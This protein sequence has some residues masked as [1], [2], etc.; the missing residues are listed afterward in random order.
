MCSGSG[1]Y[2]ELVDDCPENYGSDIFSSI[3][4]EDLQKAHKECV[5]PVSNEDYN[6]KPKYNNI[7]DLQK[8]RSSQ[9]LNPLN[10]EESIEWFK[11]QNYEKDKQDTQRAYKLAK[12]DEKTKQIN[13]LFI[14]KFKL[15]S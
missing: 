9:F 14:S 7:S 2:G 4:Y 10:K 5:V 11:K 12:Q 3:P 13:D 8:S 6:N 15:L 1:N